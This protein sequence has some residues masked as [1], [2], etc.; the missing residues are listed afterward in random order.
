MDKKYIIIYLKSRLFSMKSTNSLKI[1]PIKKGKFSY[2]GCFKK[3][4]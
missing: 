2:N 3:L 1:I 4:L